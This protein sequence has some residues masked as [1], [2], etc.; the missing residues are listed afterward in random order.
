MQRRL[1]PVREPLDDPVVEDSHNRLVHTP[2]GRTFRD[3]DVS[4]SEADYRR[5]YNGWMCAWCFE[6]WETQW[7]DACSL[8]GCW[9]P[10][11]MTEEA[12]RRYLGE[13]FGYRW[14]GI[15]R[16]THDRLANEKDRA[17]WQKRSGV[18]LPGGVS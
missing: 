3:V 5:I 7:P 1:L 17:G 6:P 15:S 8:R 2:D 10:K 9:S 12:Q 16:E 14:I 11:P 13:R 4:V 18:W